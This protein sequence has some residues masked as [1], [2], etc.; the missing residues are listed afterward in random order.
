MK[1]SQKN[2][3]RQYQAGRHSPITISDCGR[4]ELEPDE[5]ITFI[6]PA[7]AEYDVARKSWGFY[8]TPS[9]NGRLSQFSLRGVLVI[10]DVGRVFVM[11]VEA[12]RELEFEAY[13]RDENLAVLHWLDS[14]HAVQ[15]LVRLIQNKDA[16]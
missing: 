1:F 3:P 14:D 15:S 16:G 6:T 9:L 11:L 12:G 7:G 2:P 5:Q 13:L 10:N 4:L 8:A